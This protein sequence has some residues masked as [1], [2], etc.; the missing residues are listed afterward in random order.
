MNSIFSWMSIISLPQFHINRT[1]STI[2]MANIKASLLVLVF[3]TVNCLAT[4]QQEETNPFM[5]HQ[6][7]RRQ[8]N[9]ER[10]GN[11]GVRGSYTHRNTGTSFGGHL[12]NGGRNWGAEVGQTIGRGN[13]GAHYSETPFS[14]SRGASV[15]YGGTQLRHT[16][17]NGNFGTSRRTEASHSFGNNNRVGGFLERDRFSR[18]HGLSADIGRTSIS[19]QRTRDIY[20]G[21]SSSVSASRRWNAGRNGQFGINAGAS[22]RSGG[23]PSYNAGASFRYRF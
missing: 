15:G 4:G 1:P 8:V 7:H 14:R 11:D 19:A 9:L 23:R 10:Y 6:R 21:T 18:T 3:L 22:R 17:T 16:R 13:V 20:F 12:A 2:K 5:R